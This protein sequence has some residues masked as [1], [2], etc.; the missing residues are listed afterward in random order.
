MRSPRDAWSPKRSP[1]LRSPRRRK[2]SLTSC[3]VSAHCRPLV[4]SGEIRV[5]AR[6]EVPVSDDRPPL[7]GMRPRD[8]GVR[9]RAAVARAVPTAAVSRVESLSVFARSAAAAGTGPIRPRTAEAPRPGRLRHAS[10]H[11][12]DTLQANSNDRSAPAAQKAIRQYGRCDPY[13]DSD[14]EGAQHPGFGTG[15]PFA[16]SFDQST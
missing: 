2:R 11:V 5:G 1:A 3:T 10:S 13:R 9:R 8:G 12:S 15:E 4:Q 6:A 16:D 14:H 7:F